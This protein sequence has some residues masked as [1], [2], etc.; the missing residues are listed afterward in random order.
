MDSQVSHPTTEL[1][2]IHRRKRKFLNLIDI[3]K[4]DPDKLKF[5]NLRDKILS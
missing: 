2:A 5:V 1:V 3:E 4:E